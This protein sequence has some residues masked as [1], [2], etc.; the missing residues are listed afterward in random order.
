MSGQAVIPA[1]PPGFMRLAHALCAS[2][3]RRRFSS[4]E[5]HSVSPTAAETGSV[6]PRERVHSFADAAFH[7]LRLA[8]VRGERI[9]ILR[10]RFMPGILH[11]CFSLVKHFF[12]KIAKNIGKQNLAGRKSRVEKHARPDRSSSAGDSPVCRAHRPSIRRRRRSQGWSCGS[13]RSCHGR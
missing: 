4:T 13:L 6:C 2:L 3:T 8:V 5:N 9:T 7:R 12:E 11:M 1:V 10:H